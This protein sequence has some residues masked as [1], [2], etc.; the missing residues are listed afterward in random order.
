MTIIVMI[1]MRAMNIMLISIYFHNDDNND[2]KL[3]VITCSQNRENAMNFQEGTSLLSLQCRP[4]G[5][6]YFRQEDAEMN[7]QSFF[8]LRVIW[9]IFSLDNLS[10]RNHYLFFPGVLSVLSQFKPATDSL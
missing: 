4:C 2:S 8:F 1:V 10:F 7:L 3:Q 9:L 5:A 6:G